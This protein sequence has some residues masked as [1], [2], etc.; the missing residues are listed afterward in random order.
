MWYI[1]V[2]VFGVVSASSPEVGLVE[3]GG[4]LGLGAAAGRDGAVL[5]P[6]RHGVH[7]ARGQ[8]RVQERGLARC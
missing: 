1:L 3:A 6:A 2:S 5:A 8:R 7:H 4:P